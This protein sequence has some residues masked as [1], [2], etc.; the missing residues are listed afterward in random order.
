MTS[1]DDEFAGL[2]DAELAMLED[3]LLLENELR[4]K[5]RFTGPRLML[6]FLT[7]L[8]ILLWSALYARVLPSQ[9]L[10]PLN[11]PLY[12]VMLGMAIGTVHFGWKLLGWQVRSAV[13][14]VLGH[15]TAVLYLLAVLYQVS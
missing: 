3:E 2:S 13:R 4:S 11:I 5:G 9:K 15:W 12:V 8:S 1:R 14:F 7:F 6:F 10:G